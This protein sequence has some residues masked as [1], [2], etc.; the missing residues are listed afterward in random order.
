LGDTIVRGCEKV[1][2]REVCELAGV[3]T[4]MNI[5]AVNL[6]KMTDKIKG[7]P[8]IKDVS[9]GRE[10]PNRLVIEIVERKPAALIKK[11]EDLYIIDRNEEIFKGLGERDCINLPVLTGFSENGAVNKGLLKMAFDLLD[12]L[13][14]SD[15]FP[16][17][18]NVSEING[19]D[20]YG[21]S[22]F[23][24]NQMFIQLGFENYEKKFERLNRILLDLAKKDLDEGC[25]KIDLTD[26][27]RVI[28]QQRGYFDRKKPKGRSRTKI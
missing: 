1:S 13:S 2:E 26:Y 20:I 16:K 19:S 4:S 9:I 3:D 24:N 11:N 22:V 25:L 7:N 6:D 14:R 21:F 27:N 17:M 28:V 5:L 18:K 8:W 23:T 12:Y 15:T 10:L